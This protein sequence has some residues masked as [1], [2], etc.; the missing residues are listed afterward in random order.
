MA[1]RARVAWAPLNV[2]KHGDTMLW[3]AAAH[4]EFALE[5]FQKAASQCHFVPFFARLLSRG[6]ELL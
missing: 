6:T 5:P 3:I 4:V 1:L 2:I